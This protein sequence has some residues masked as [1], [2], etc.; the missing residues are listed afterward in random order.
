MPV[1]ADTLLEKDLLPDWLIRLGIRRLLRERLREED[2]GDPASRRARL[3]RFVDE[4]R[5][6]PVAIETKAANDQHYEVPAA[7]FVKCLGPHRKYSCAWWPRNVTTLEDAEDAMLELTCDRA[8]LEDGQSVLELGCGWGSL[9]LYMAQAFPNS[10]I[11][12]V[13]N[14]RS[15][16]RFIDAESARLGVRNLEIVTADMNRFDTE[17]RF[18]RVVSVEMF[19]HMRNY[20]ELMRRI[21]SWSNP[22]ALLFVHIFTH[23]RFAYAFEDRG[24]GDWMARHFFTGGIMPSD[25][26]LLHFQDDFSIL[27]HWRLDGTHYQKTAEAWLDNMDAH[28]WEILDIFEQTYG[29][30]DALRWFVRWRLFYM[31][32]AELWGYRNGKEWLVS[33]Y[34]FEKK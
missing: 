14:S 27:E 23:S 18:D 25:D 20:E 22:G 15:Q 2:A 13:S 17:R 31:A 1:T 21:A 12:A 3:L 26:L 11:M 19:E 16:K 6:S 10:R 33:H 4:L 7:F 8:R 30:D 9:S 32:C 34:L 5:A 24:P 28:R 29:A